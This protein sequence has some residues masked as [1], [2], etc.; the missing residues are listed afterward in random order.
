MPLL[1][2]LPRAVPACSC[3]GEDSPPFPKGLGP[4]LQIKWKWGIRRLRSPAAEGKTRLS[5]SLHPSCCPATLAPVFPD[6]HGDTQ[7]PLC[8][9]RAL[10]CA[11]RGGQRWGE[12]GRVTQGDTES[13]F[14]LP[15]PATETQALHTWGV[16]A[17]LIIT[18]CCKGAGN[19]RGKG[20]TPTWVSSQGQGAQGFSQTC[21][22]ALSA[23]IWSSVPSQHHSIP[24]VPFPSA[25]CCRWAQRGPA[26]GQCPAQRGLSTCVC[27]FHPFATHIPPPQGLSRLRAQKPGGKRVLGD[28]SCPCGG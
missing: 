8:H 23:I 19:L 3:V 9:P 14:Q 28:A 7:P 6:T 26:L 21:P 22:V 27:C 1:W 11:P 12:G 4:C 15:I 17:G 18:P 10:L 13:Q 24:G 5:C 20:E 2:C 16:M 25:G